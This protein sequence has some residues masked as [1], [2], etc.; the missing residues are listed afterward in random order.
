MTCNNSVAI[1]TGHV[2]WSCTT[3]ALTI[4]YSVLPAAGTYTFT[5]AV[6]S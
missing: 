2:A 1:D 4:T 5:Y 6:L 3:T